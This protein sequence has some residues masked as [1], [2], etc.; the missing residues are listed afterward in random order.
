MR[1][2]RTKESQVL[3]KNELSLTS[4]YLLC[5]IYKYLEDNNVQDWLNSLYEQR[6]L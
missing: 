2:Y 5:C 6:N 3:I 4:F 1:S